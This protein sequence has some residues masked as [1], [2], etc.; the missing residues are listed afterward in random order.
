MNAFISCARDSTNS[1][2]IGDFE[3]KV[4][5]TIS[6]PNGICCFE[7]SKRPSFIITGGRDKII[8]LWNPF[9]LTKPAANLTGHM[10]AIMA[11]VVNHEESQFISLSEDK[12]IKIWNVRNLNCLQTMI[13][14]MAHR[15]E[16]IISSIFFDSHNRRILTGSANV[17]IW[18]VIEYSLIFLAYYNK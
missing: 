16:N 3:R 2:V 12:V 8:R 11:I 14:K 17:E 15:P 10:T 18:P 13:D 7:V 5:R 9:I 1:I 4:N 6:V